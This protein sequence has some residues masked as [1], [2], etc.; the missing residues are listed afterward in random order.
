MR[1]LYSAKGAVRVSIDPALKAVFAVW[2]D[3]NVPR[4]FR[5]CLE[6]QAAAVEQ[7]GARY[8]VVD[9]TRA[10]GV[11]SQADQDFLCQEVIPRYERAGLAAIITVLPACALTA[12]GA[13]RWRRAG[14]TYRFG[15]YETRTLSDAR[16]LILRHAAGKAA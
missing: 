3:F 16:E 8:V 13:Q 6:A 12:M 14:A 1:R 7:W 9:L 11:P 5:P 4:V 2:N 10:S 15:M